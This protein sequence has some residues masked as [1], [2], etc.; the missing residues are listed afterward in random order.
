MNHV[1][2]LPG[3]H[4]L[5]EE[6]ARIGLRMHPKSDGR[7]CSFTW[8]VEPGVTG[9]LQTETVAAPDHCRKH[10]CT[11]LICLDE[12]E[13]FEAE[14]MGRPKRDLCSA[15]GISPNLVRVR[16]VPGH[17]ELYADARRE[18]DPDEAG[19]RGSGRALAE[20]VSVL[21]MPEW[22]RATSVRAI[23]SRNPQLLEG[24]YQRHAV[25]LLMLGRNDEAR[26][27]MMERYS[28]DVLNKQA[29][30]EELA[31]ADSIAARLGIRPWPPAAPVGPG[32]R[33]K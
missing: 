15:E 25:A 8:E 19:Y 30:P 24:C 16:G 4:L 20:L 12:L 7:I 23:Y 6:L 10:H 31:I 26:A 33:A 17:T 2:F 28:V 21:E 3:A 9:V 13:T 11:S 18:F 27:A 32:R 5:A 29:P 22:R 1:K 14:L